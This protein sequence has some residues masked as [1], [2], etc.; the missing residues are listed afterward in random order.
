MLQCKPENGN[1]YIQV[2]IIVKCKKKPLNR[3]LCAIFTASATR[4]IQS[5]SCI[6]HLWGSCYPGPGSFGDSPEMQV[7]AQTH[8]EPKMYRLKWA[9]GWFSG[10]TYLSILEFGFC[11][12]Q[13]HKRNPSPK[14]CI[15][16]PGLL[17]KFIHYKDPLH[18][19]LLVIY[20]NT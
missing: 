14:I 8:K 15:T 2:I 11:H 13:K 16:L 19:E 1:K 9:R 3:I 10:N 7:N 12:V 17:I 20:C 6:V 5:I 18:T 4:P